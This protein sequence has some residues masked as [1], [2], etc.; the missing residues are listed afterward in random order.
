MIAIISFAQFKILG[1]D[2]EYQEKGERRCKLKNECFKVV[3]GFVLAILTILFVFPFYWILTGA[4][5]SQPATIVIPPEWWPK[6]A[7]GWKLP[8]IDGAKLAMQWMWNS[9]FISLAT[10][11]LVWRNVFFGRMMFWLRSG[12]MVNGF[13][14]NLH[15]SHGFA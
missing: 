14:C 4:F 9:V 8:A 13:F 2:V 3:S 7:N 5:K 15:C 1:N 10:M 6:N 12:S 11:F